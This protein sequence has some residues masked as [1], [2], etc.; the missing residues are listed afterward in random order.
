MWLKIIQKSNCYRLPEVL[1]IYC[2]HNNSISSGSKLKLIKYH[3]IL[4]NKA[5]NMN[6]FLSILFTLR[7]LVWGVHKKIYYK[8]NFGSL[9]R[10]KVRLHLQE[11]P[12]IMR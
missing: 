2:K 11:F 1:S 9:L 6:A 10:A 12:L 3:Y 4:F 7:N 8:K 5:Q